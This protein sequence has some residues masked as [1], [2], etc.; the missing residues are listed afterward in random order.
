MALT[1]NEALVQET[2]SRLLDKLAPNTFI[3]K[4]RK[5]LGKSSINKPVDLRLC[6][7]KNPRLTLVS[8]EVSAVN[9]TQLPS[10]VL[11]LYFDACPRKLL[12]LMKQNTP[13]NGKELS[14]EIFCLLYAQKKITRTPAQVA[15]H[16]NE[17]GL[18]KCLENLLLL[19][20]AS[21]EKRKS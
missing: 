15:W 21:S 17:D 4:E 8:I 18:G 2:I 13:K 12:V 11:R 7:R 5:G 20:H 19:Q 16:D 10:E 14:E 3:C 1:D 6:S 9:T